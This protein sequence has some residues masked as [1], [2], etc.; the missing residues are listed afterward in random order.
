LRFRRSPQIWGGCLASYLAARIE[1]SDS[2]TIDSSLEACYF[3]TR[4]WFD[5]W[6]SIYHGFAT[7]PR[8][9]A[10]SGHVGWLDQEGWDAEACHGRMRRIAVRGRLANLP[11]INIDGFQVE[12]DKMWEIARFPM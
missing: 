8:R 7:E 3:S 9:F 2:G 10:V 6:T 11:M 4:K 1:N 5:D 12:V